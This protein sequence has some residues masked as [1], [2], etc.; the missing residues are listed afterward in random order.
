MNTSHNLAKIRP[1]ILLVLMLSLTYAA[2]PIPYVKFSAV[3]TE[4]DDFS[5]TNPD[6]TNNFDRYGTQSEIVLDNYIILFDSASIPPSFTSQ[7]KSLQGEITS[8]LGEAGMVIVS[9]TNPDFAREAAKI[10]GVIAVAPDMKKQWI[11][12]DWSTKVIRLP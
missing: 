4:A 7:I 10:E 1:I 3:D 5:S 11:D 12:P 9:S 2:N 8:D 6:F